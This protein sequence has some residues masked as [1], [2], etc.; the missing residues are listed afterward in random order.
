MPVST[1]AHLVMAQTDGPEGAGRSLAL[2][3]LD[4]VA[5]RP[6]IA[7]EFLT[8]FAYLHHLS[9]DTERAAYIN[10]HTLAVVLGPIQRLMLFADVGVTGDGAIDLYEARQKELPMLELYR[11]SIE[12]GPRLLSEEIERWS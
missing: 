11:R 2:V 3:A 8:A 7:G 9:G 6:Q 12:H 10:D 4:A 1:I 5:R